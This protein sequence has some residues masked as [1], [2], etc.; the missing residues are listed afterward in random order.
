ML[1]K[2]VKS[3]YYA[4]DPVTPPDRF[5]LLVFS[6]YTCCIL[7]AAALCRMVVLVPRRRT[8]TP[9]I[10]LAAYALPII[11]GIVKNGFQL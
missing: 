2:L 6:F 1:G 11:V 5:V 9:M 10:S 3:I 8:H 7:S 4:V